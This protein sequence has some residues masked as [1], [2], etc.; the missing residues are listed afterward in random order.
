VKEQE[1]EN[2][3]V[4]VTETVVDGETVKDAEVERETVNDTEVERETVTDTE[5]ESVLVIVGVVVP[6]R[7]ES[8]TT[9]FKRFVERFPRSCRR[10]ANNIHF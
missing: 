6:S 10:A 2:V 1:D 8:K 3:V 4:V 5:V 7:A 9:L